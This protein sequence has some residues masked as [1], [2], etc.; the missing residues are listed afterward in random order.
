M[1]DYSMYGARKV[2]SI[3]FK[4]KLP[5]FNWDLFIEDY[6]NIYRIWRLITK[7]KQHPDQEII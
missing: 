6:K 2:N 4:M 3:Y 7:R 5:F 1:I